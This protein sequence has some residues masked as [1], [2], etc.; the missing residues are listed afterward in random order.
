MKPASAGYLLAMLD[1]IYAH[2][3]VDFTI[4]DKDNYDWPFED[5]DPDELESLTRIMME[6]LRRDIAKVMDDI[7]SYKTTMLKYYEDCGCN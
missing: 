4:T 2:A 1:G 3:T 6:D 7:H 5:G